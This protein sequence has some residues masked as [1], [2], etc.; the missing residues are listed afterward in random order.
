MLMRVLW[1]HT[2]S[3]PPTPPTPPTTRHRRHRRRHR[4]CVHVRFQRAVRRRCG[5]T[6][7]RS[8]APHTAPH[9]CSTHT[10]TH[11]HTCSTHTH[12]QAGGDGSNSHE[13]VASRR[14]ALTF[15]TAPWTR[16]QKCPAAG[17]PSPRKRRQTILRPCLRWR[18]M[19]GEWRETSEV[20]VDIAAVA[21][22]KSVLIL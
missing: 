21:E 2:P 17:S 18:K 19:R 4:R 12:M 14:A 5:D 16:G 3:T 11:T 9:T 20:N 22:A 8:T 10:H 7:L 15:R 6:Q 1:A 13:T